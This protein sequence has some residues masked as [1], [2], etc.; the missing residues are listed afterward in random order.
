MS[1]FHKTTKWKNK[2][3]NILRRDEYMCRECNRYGKTI[4]AT[5]VHHV[6]PVDERPDLGLSSKNLISLCKTCH[7]KMHDRVTNQLT[8]LGIAWVERIYKE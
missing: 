3:G 5:M 1:A 6:I 7:G 8:A 4:E 2:R